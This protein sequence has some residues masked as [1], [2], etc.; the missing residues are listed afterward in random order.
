MKRTGYSS[1]E[2]SAAGSR[3]LSPSAHAFGSP[4]CMER[5]Y[6]ASASSSRGG[7]SSCFDVDELNLSSPADVGRGGAGG[8]PVR[9]QLPPAVV[10]PSFSTPAPLSSSQ[11]SSLTVTLP[12]PHYDSDTQTETDSFT[13][14]AAFFY[15]SD[16][17]PAA[18]YNPDTQIETD[19]FT[20]PAAFHNSDDDSDS[21]ADTGT[22]TETDESD[23]QNRGYIK[24][25]PHGSAL[26]IYHRPDGI[27]RCPV[28]PGLRQWWTRP[29]E[30][31]DHVVGKAN[32]SALRAE[33]K[34]KV[35]PPPRSGLE[36]GVDVSEPRAACAGHLE[37]GTG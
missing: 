5:P 27:Y 20:L 22:Q 31:R 19:S 34:K 7:F 12:A 26:C 33:N 3:R 14:P 9:S 21:N 29:N 10:A 1:V 35:Q 15:D 24:P 30:V 2:A 16:T 11:P 36:R 18:F 25:V 28:Y 23:D 37:R 17:L 4:P 13:L 6:G 8:S 32:S